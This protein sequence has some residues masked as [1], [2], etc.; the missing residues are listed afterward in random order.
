MKIVKTRSIPNVDDERLLHD[1]ER[2][3]RVL[4][5]PAGIAE[6]SETRRSLIQMGVKAR[7]IQAEL[8]RR[9]H[10]PSRCRYCSGPAPDGFTQ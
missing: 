2:L 3:H 9:G 8:V 4:H 10:Q 1:L 6:F 5:T 7:R